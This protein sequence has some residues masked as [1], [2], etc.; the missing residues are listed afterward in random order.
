MGGL[1]AY[2]S[3]PN[4]SQFHLVAFDMRSLIANTL[5]HINR[6]EWFSLIYQAIL[7]QYTALQ[8]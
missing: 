6:G 2:L 1:V 5:S 8:S 7:S 3:P 4:C